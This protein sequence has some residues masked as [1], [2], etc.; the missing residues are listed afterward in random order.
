MAL[1]AMA[2]TQ[3]DEEL[4]AA[5]RQVIGDNYEHGRH[6]IGAAVRMR[7]GRVFAGVHVEANVGRIA[8]CAE[9]VALGTALSAGA[10]GVETVVAVAHPAAHESRSEAWVVA[11]CGMCRELISDF[12]PDAWVIM[13][14]AE[15]PPVK[16][17]V[18]DLLPAKYSRRR[19]G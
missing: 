5:A 15:G 10:R 4:V 12:G 9:A 13:P 1:R 18:L 2:L 8:L 16:V 19:P 11:P 17:G 14:S 6:H 7:D 3:G